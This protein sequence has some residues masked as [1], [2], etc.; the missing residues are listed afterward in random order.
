MRTL[1]A[2]SETVKHDWFVV[3]ASNKVLGRLCSEIARRLKGKH[4]VD[5]TTHV[6][7][8]DYIVVIN[9]GQVK[10]TGNKTTDKIYYR[11][12]GYPGGV[13]TITFDKLLARDP[14]QVIEHSV[15][16]M[17]PKNPLGREMFRKLKVYAGETHPH[18]AQEPKLLEV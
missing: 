7:A 5:Y 12:T 11:H 10:V 8:G 9:A 2:K 17:L 15:K 4:K 18:S 13:K 14:I 1:S 3:D 16:G 6:D